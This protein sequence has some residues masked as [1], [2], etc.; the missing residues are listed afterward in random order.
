M[1]WLRGWCH[2]GLCPQT[3]GIYRVPA[4]I[5]VLL[6]NWGL[7]PQTPGALREGDGGPVSLLFRPLSRRSGCVPA[8][9]YPPLRFFQGGRLQ[10]RRATIVQ[11]TAITPLT[12]CRTPRVHFK[13]AQDT[14][15]S[16]R[17]YPPGAPHD[18]EQNSTHQDTADGGYLEK[19][20]VADLARWVRRY[21]IELIPELPSFTHSY[22]LMTEHPD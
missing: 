19:E 14:N 17:N 10:P 5:A 22:Y 20:E 11:R 9:P 8:E 6:R 13:F 21:H 7:R 1:R 2:W 4:R 12:S 15:Y 3:P 16:R 18:W